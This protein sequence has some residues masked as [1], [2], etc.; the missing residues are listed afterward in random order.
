MK[1]ICLLCFALFFSS[2]SQSSINKGTSNI[3]ILEL[4]KSKEIWSNYKKDSNNSYIYFTNFASWSGFG[5]ET[6]IT[7][8]N[9]TFIKREY[10]SWNRKNEETWIETKKELGIHKLGAKLKFIDELYQ[11]CKNILTSKDKSVNNIYLGFDKKGLLS[12]CLYAPKNCAD[13]CSN[14]VRIK[15]IKFTN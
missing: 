15:E 7:V 14:G 3:S 2:C 9:G 13:D 5:H 1:L 10:V 12:Y 6:K 11:D 8:K 4:E